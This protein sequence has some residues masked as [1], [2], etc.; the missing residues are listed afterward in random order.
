ML[1][2]NPVLDTRLVETPIKNPLETTK[3]E[4]RR[5]TNQQQMDRAVPERF[6]ESNQRNNKATS[7]D[8]NVPHNAKLQQ[9]IA[10]ADDLRIHNN[11]SPHE[12]RI[13][14]KGAVVQMEQSRQQQTDQQEAQ[15]NVKV[16]KQQPLVPTTNIH[17][18]PGALSQQEFS[19]R[20]DQKQQ[21]E[22][23]MAAARENEDSFNQQ[24][25]DVEFNLRLP[26]NNS[27]NRT[28]PVLPR[29]GRT[30][31]IIYDPLRAEHWPFPVGQK[32]PIQPAVPYLGTLIDAGRHYFPIPW[33][34]KVIDLLSNMN[35]N[36]IHLRLTD[37]QAFHVLL[38]SRPQLAYPTALWN[39]DRNV[40][41]AKEL[42]DLVAYARARNIAIMPEINLPGHAGAWA[43]I[44]D[45]VVSCPEFTCAK[46]YGLPLNVTHANV[47]AIL[48][49]VLTEIIDIFDNPPFLHLGGDEVNMGTCVY[50]WV[51]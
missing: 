7:I 42:V 1:L 30:A 29:L 33:L 16:R 27:T 47:R 25:Q 10:S 14:S 46:G 15:T 21:L 9:H 51:E 50:E 12:D 18:L 19:D 38:Q 41:T 32:I 8:K 26:R 48:K 39:D 24:Q 11:K 22:L 35:Y 17:A 3:H 28:F 34:K 40:Y 6:A 37:D 49:D 2:S 4:T 13:L 36:F 5:R 43:G 31:P 23:I 44:P 45:L 20:V